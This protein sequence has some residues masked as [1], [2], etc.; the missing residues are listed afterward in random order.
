MRNLPRKELRDSR[1]FIPRRPARVLA[2]RWN[3]PEAKVSLKAPLCPGRP[4]GDRKR[5]A[6]EIDRVLHEC[7]RLARNTLPP[8]TS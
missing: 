2:K 4:P 1:I 6:H 5:P 8:D 7:E 3:S